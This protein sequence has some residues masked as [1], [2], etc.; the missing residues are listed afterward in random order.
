MAN[1]VDLIPFSYT[2]K[3]PAPAILDLRTLEDYDFPDIPMSYSRTISTRYDEP[4]P[5]GTASGPLHYTGT[6]LQVV[7]CELDLLVKFQLDIE[8]I[9][10]FISFC[11]SA[12]IPDGS[13][14]SFQ[15]A[16]PTDLLLTWPNE[17]E[18][19]CKLTEFTDNPVLFFNDTGRIRR[20]TVRLRFKEIVD[21]VL[22]TTEVKTR[23]SR[24]ARIFQ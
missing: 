21:G 13:A 12:L 15:S 2:R 10:R 18:I 9:E 1:G 20:R 3:M 14:G 16:D 5:Y 22:T 8:R 6:G 4:G 24:R 23:G 7:E 19:V 17:L 11:E